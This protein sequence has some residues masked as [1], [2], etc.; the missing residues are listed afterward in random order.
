MTLQ[1]FEQP[2][3]RVLSH[4][5]ERRLNHKHCTGD[6][7]GGRFATIAS[8][9]RKGHLFDRCGKL[10]ITEKGEHYLFHHGPEMPV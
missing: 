10:E 3:A 2:P 4:A 6:C 1:D 5:E 7:G 8:L 9:V